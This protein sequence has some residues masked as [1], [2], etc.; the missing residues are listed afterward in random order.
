MHK[1]IELL[2]NI[3]II[4]AAV[5]LVALAINKFFLS[6]KRAPLDQVA[7]H[8]KAGDKVTLPGFDWTR[9][10]RTL[11][12]AL[13]VNC[14]YCTESAP[15]YQHL[16]A[17]VSKHPNTHLLSVLP[18]TTEAGRKYLSELGITIEDVRQV[19]LNAVGVAGTPT[20]ILVDKEGTV[21]RVWVGKLPVSAQ[22][23]VISQL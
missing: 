6:P 12:M 20:L 11:V 2:A 8:L 15:F 9:S 4:I 22:S 16:T 5:L 17:E 10:E 19:P 1:K 14:H 18:Q 21:K 3:A 23:E 7:A 13:S